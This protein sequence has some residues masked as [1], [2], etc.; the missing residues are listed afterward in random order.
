MKRNWSQTPDKPITFMAKVSEEG[1]S[2]TNPNENDSIQEQSNVDLEHMYS[3]SNWRRN[4]FSAQ[5]VSV[6]G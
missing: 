1:H 6:R 3:N 4:N 2:V 5:V